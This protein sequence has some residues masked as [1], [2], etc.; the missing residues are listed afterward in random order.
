M[1]H[2]IQFSRN[3]E[4]ILASADERGL[5][6]IA[7]W[8]MLIPRA[9]AIEYVK[10]YNK[11]SAEGFFKYEDKVVISHGAGKLTLTEQEASAVVELIKTAYGSLF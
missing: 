6:V 8:S 10:N 3:I 7:G 5:M 9:T 1:A 4:N 2:E 11:S